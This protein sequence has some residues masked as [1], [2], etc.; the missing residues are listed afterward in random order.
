MTANL[1]VQVVGIALYPIVT[2]LYSPETVGA[3]SLFLAIVGIFTTIASG[4]YE[5][6][7][8]A[9]RNNQHASGLIHLCLILTLVTGLIIAIAERCIGGSTIADMLK[10]PIL[11]DYLWLVAPLVV[12]SAL[13]YM[14]TFVFNRQ[15]MFQ[16]TAC[17]TAT[18]G[19]VGNVLRVLFGFVGMLS[20][21]L[22]WA[23]IV[24]H[25]A[26]LLSVAWRIPS[27]TR[28][29]TDNRE[30]KMMLVIKA[31]RRHWR[32]PA[33]NLPHALISTV[34][35]NLPIMILAL[36]YPT[37][38]VGFFALCV[39]FG[40]KPVNVFALS[41]NQALFQTASVATNSGKS[42]FRHFV[43]F[44]LRTSLVATPIVVVLYIIMPTVTPV[45]FG[46][47]WSG[48]TEIMR[49]LLPLLL[50]TTLSTPF[51]FVPLLH[52]RQATALAIETTS[53]VCR[54][55]VLIIGSQTTDITI[56]TVWFALTHSLFLAIQLVWY[57]SL[58]KR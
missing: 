37:E 53:S 56:T 39:T 15:D 55:A 14:L 18:Q 38:S 32:Y 8:V 35:N 54:I 33:F 9:E 31:M 34:S 52:N 16:L 51:N 36:A 7:I 45:L 3:L 13:G 27:I 28:L 48:S 2:R 17:Y 50:L 6:A 44:T 12:L 58:E 21:G 11:A 25:V 42:N 1:I 46:D 24:G 10:T 29:T 4:R 23:N 43:N 20:S 49:A 57:L 47:E 26:G 19:I 40:Y 30:S 41:M 22:Y 5:Q